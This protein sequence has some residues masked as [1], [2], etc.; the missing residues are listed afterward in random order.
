MSIRTPFDEM[1]SAFETMRRSMEEMMAGRGDAAGDWRGARAFRL[2]RTEEGY[3]LVA[4]LPGFERDEID[5][6]I[7]GDDLLLIAD[8]ER[9]I[10]DE[11]GETLRHRSVRKAM[12]LP[13]GVSVDEIS[14]SYN[15]GVL[16]VTMPVAGERDA[17]HVQID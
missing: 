17:T 2:D 7:D 15:N 9:R 4:D 14:A 11:I 3:T 1:D 8:N 12:S 6:R 10:A 5:L 13:E 16:Q